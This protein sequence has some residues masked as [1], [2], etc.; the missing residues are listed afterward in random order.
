[1]K[2]CVPTCIQATRAKNKSKTASTSHGILV[3][4]VCHAPLRLRNSGMQVANQ[5]LHTTELTGYVESDTG[6]RLG[7]RA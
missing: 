4:Y 5:Y 3:L 7:T 6:A 1:M 2:T